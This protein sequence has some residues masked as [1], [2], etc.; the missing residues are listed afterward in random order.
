[1]TE[2]Q[3]DRAEALVREMISLIGDD[4]TREGVR[5]TPARVVRSWQELFS[6]YDSCAEDCL[7]EFESDYDQV[8]ALRGI[9]FFSF[10]EHHMLPFVGT[11]SV[12]YLPSNGKVIGVSKIARIVEVY[13]RRLQIQEQ[14]TQQIATAVETLLKPSGVAVLVDGAHLCMMARGVSQR[15]A[16]MVTSCLRGRFREDPSARSEVLRLLEKR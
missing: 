16:T 14:M 4:P 9:R 2:E 8:I 5:D 13:A 3:K 7:T 12:A 15:E 1:M 10:C 11:C 6:G